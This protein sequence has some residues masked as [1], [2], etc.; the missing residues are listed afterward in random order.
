MVAL[1]GIEPAGRQS[2]SVQLSLSGC[3]FSLVRTG[4]WAFRA[5]RVVG[6]VPWSSPGRPLRPELACRSYA[7]APCG[8]EPTGVWLQNSES[9]HE[10]TDRRVTGPPRP[11]LR[12]SAIARQISGNRRRANPP[13]LMLVYTSINCE[14]AAH[15]PHAFMAGCQ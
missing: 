3:I 12:D 5:L 13:R 10:D 6:V 2:D 11:A 4:R 15:G 1:T 7:A 14:W 8:V 9:S